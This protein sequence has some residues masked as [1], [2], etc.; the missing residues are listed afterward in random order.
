MVFNGNGGQL[1]Q[2]NT[3]ASLQIGDGG[4]HAG[5]PWG[6][7][8]FTWQVASGSVPP[9]LTL[10]AGS[11]TSNV[12]LTGTPTSPGCFTFALQV[13]D[14]TAVSSAPTT[15]NV[16]VLPSPLKVQ[17]PTYPSS[18]N[19]A[20]NGT[21]SSSDPGV[22]YPP[23][24]LV[25]SGGTAPYVWSPDPFGQSTIQSGLSLNPSTSNSSVAVISGTPAVGADAG[26]NLVGSAVGAYPTLFYANDSQAP[27]PAVGVANL[28]NMSAL[29]VL[30]QSGFCT[31][32]T[33]APP[34]VGSPNGV[35]ANSYLQGSVAFLLKG[36]DGNGPVVMAGSFTADGNGGISAGEEDLTNSSGSQNFTVTSGTYTVGTSSLATGL[37]QSQSYSRGCMIL[38]LKNTVTAATTTTTFAFTLGG[39]S[40]HNMENQVT[41]TSDMACGLALNGGTNV[42]A[43]YFTTG[44]II[45]FDDQTE[46]GTRVTGILRLQDT[47][48]FSSG[49][50]GP[51]AFGMAGWD[52]AGGHYALA[53]SLLAS[54]GALNSVAAD[55]NDAGT[56]NSALT[57]GSGTYS[58]ADANGRS[59]GSLTVGQASY[60][61][62]FYAVGKNE[63]FIITTDSLSQ[64][65]PI[66]AGEAISTAGSFSNA[67]VQ[68]GQIFHIAGLS[69]AGPDVSVGV[70]TFD[71]VSAYSGTVYQDQAATLGTT[72]VSGAYAVDGT[73]G[74]TTLIGQVNVN[75][76]GSHSFVAYVIPSAANLT[77]AGCVTPASC[78][79]GFLV[80]TDSTA[81][82][83]I[84][85][86]QTTLIAPPPPFTNR[87][88][89]GDYVYGTDESIDRATPVLEGNVLPLPSS[90]STTSGNF[91]QSVSVPGAAQDVSYGSFGFCS[92]PSCFLMPSQSLTGTYS[93]NPN[94]TGTFGGGTTSVTNGNVTFYIDES[95]IN[96]HPSI[97]VAEQ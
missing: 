18:F 20:Q 14:G 61:V 19:V 4:Y 9:G 35:P 64:N 48:S 97:I 95:P 23:T 63:D 1:M 96:L 55:I 72:A 10:G 33:A 17:I 38:T 30:P 7:A 76:L 59:T 74:R 80:G 11:D 67:S 45:E 68:N 32:A 69:S 86:F 56:L 87:Y 81:Q 5:A 91:N 75:P 49:M 60:D 39:C 62:A 29:G 43:G 57:G 37:S 3:F 12:Y 83:G 70:L 15:F 73:T 31:P 79:T 44:R 42:A 51:Y 77:R 8:P 88:V 16:V 82:D 53:G 13:T 34:V 40:N 47:T 6:V 89:E 66:I 93:V 85:E 78:V 94:G 54:A 65:H 58:T 50:S 46:Q 92:D 71:G 90:S 26:S 25:A 27:Y 22:P 36:F 52:F 24:A 84:L 21:V 41:R 2:V 28:A